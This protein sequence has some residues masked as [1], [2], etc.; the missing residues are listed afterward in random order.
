MVMVAGIK[1]DVGENHASLSLPYVPELRL[2]GIQVVVPSKKPVTAVEIE[3]TRAKFGK[4]LRKQLPLK[5]GRCFIPIGENM[6]EVITEHQKALSDEE[7]AKVFRHINS[8]FTVFPDKVT[9]AS[10]AEVYEE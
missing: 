4:L 7:F 3:N 6:A 5:D 1:L 2:I 8:L 9:K 10:I